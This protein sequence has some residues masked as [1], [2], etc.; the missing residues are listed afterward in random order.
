MNIHPNAGHL[1]KVFQKAA[2][3][4]GCERLEYKETQQTYPQ[5]RIGKNKRQ[6]IKLI[7]KPDEGGNR[8]IQLD[9]QRWSKLQ[10]KSQPGQCCLETTSRINPQKSPPEE[11]RSLSLRAIKRVTRTCPS[12]YRAEQGEL[13][14]HPNLPQTPRR[15]R[16]LQQE[17]SQVGTDSKRRASQ[18]AIQNCL[19]TQGAS[20]SCKLMFPF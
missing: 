13:P 14:A 18:G 15:I 5:T 9:C 2:P 3:C 12:G 20:I 4:W 17:R 19:L 1:L 6:M 16:G 11:I 8:R 7:R 10:I